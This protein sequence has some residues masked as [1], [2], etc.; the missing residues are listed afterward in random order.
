MFRCWDACQRLKAE[1]QEKDQYLKEYTV[2]V[3]MTVGQVAAAIYG[4]SSKGGEIMQL[5]IIAD[6]L[7]IEPG[8][9][10]RYYQAV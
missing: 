3:R 8:T 1:I 7:N 10:L 9:K 2:P 4:D 5:N 6:P